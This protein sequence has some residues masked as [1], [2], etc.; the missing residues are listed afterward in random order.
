MTESTAAVKN[1]MFMGGNDD[2]TAPA[3]SSDS[4]LDDNLMDAVG[5]AEESAMDA[6][7]AHEHAKM[8]NQLVHAL[9]GDGHH[10]H[11]VAMADDLRDQIKDA[12]LGGDA[13]TARTA[14]R[15][16]SFVRETILEQTFFGPL[17]ESQ[18][19]R[20]TDNIQ[21]QTGARKA[22]AFD[23][24]PECVIVSTK[25]NWYGLLY[26]GTPQRSIYD[27]VQVVAVLYTCFI[28][29]LRLAFDSHAE[30]WSLV[31]MWDLLI[32]TGFILDIVYNFNAYYLDDSQAVVSDKAR[33]RAKYMR[34]WFVLDFVASFPIDYIVRA[35]GGSQDSDEWMR[36]FRLLRLSRLARTTRLLRALKAK[37]FQAFNSMVHTKL[38]QHPVM[39]MM[40][41]MFRFWFFIFGLSH[42]IAC[43][44][45]HM[46]RSVSLLQQPGSTDVNSWLDPDYVDR[47][48][49][50][51][52]APAGTETAQYWDALYWVIATMSSVGYGDICAH[53]VNEKAFSVFVMVLGGFMWAYV[54]A[55]FSEVL[56]AAMENQ[57]RYQGKVRK[58]IRYLGFM[59]APAPMVMN[60]LAFYRY[61]HDKNTLFDLSIFGELPPRLRRQLVVQRYQTTLF[62]VPFFRTCNDDTLCQLCVKLQPFCA[63]KD[64]VIIYED[65]S[66]RDLFVVE[67]GAAEAFLPGKA[68]AVEFYPEGSFFGE[69]NFFGLGDSTTRSAKVKAATYAELS[70]ISYLDL[71]NVLEMDAALRDRLFG[72]ARLRT[73]LYKLDDNEQTDE[74]K[75]FEAASEASLDSSLE[76]VRDTIEETHE[77]LFGAGVKKV[78]APMSGASHT[79][80]LRMDKQDEDIAELKE[81]MRQMLAKVK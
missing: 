26:P 78:T 25:E 49:F 44:F 76:S 22:I 51:H 23:P 41:Q 3:N 37:R 27:F 33:I 66:A 57:R 70:W 52:D 11:R 15:V 75:M 9:G 6:I 30:A 47:I 80:N 71:H 14:M 54:I 50:T 59:N 28:V 16:K 21:E 10:S 38:I 77:K 35:A 18:S 65:D 24:D 45:L 20:D 43:V 56:S 32:D 68:E 1:P 72:F 55:L 81:M 31:F 46:G 7:T 64:E 79:V 58:V 74:T 61:R 2:D 39:M 67:R 34:T 42:F 69:V 29:P 62:K 40:W 17:G 60:V 5:L 36:N 8:E 73:A 12:A 19:V 63:A 48:Y 4:A 13:D 53:N